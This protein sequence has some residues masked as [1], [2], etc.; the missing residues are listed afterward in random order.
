[1]SISWGAVLLIAFAYGL[2]NSTDLLQLN[3][4]YSEVKTAQIKHYTML[5]DYSNSPNS[6]PCKLMNMTTSAN[7]NPIR[8]W[9]NQKNDFTN[10]LSFNSMQFN[11][12]FAIIASFDNCYPK[13]CRFPF[14]Q[15]QNGFLDYL[16]V[17]PLS[18]DICWP[19]ADHIIEIY[20]WNI[21][22]LL[23]SYIT[24]NI[25]SIRSLRKALSFYIYYALGDSHCTKHILDELDTL[26]F[27]D[28]LSILKFVQYTRPDLSPSLILQS[29][30]KAV[31]VNE[32]RNFELIEMFKVMSKKASSN[33]WLV[34]IIAT[35]TKRKW[36]QSNELMKEYFPVNITLG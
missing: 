11:C 36:L 21:F 34:P 28:F 1:M 6:L 18:I 23:P 3:K 7:V 13:D 9:L 19:I 31:S 27:E 32:T 29:I 25:A 33:N 26:Q 16:T 5:C 24:T 10:K 4:N 17:C 2:M 15:I 8:L 20:A 22:N 30:D 35:S 12:S 14:R